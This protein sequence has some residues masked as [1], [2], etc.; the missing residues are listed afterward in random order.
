MVAKSVK[1][2]SLP[3]EMRSMDQPSGE[4]REGSSWKHWL[5]YCAAFSGVFRMVDLGWILAEGDQDS[6]RRSRLPDTA[7]LPCSCVVEDGS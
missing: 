2:L 6:E 3:W 1:R 7:P 4:T 5:R